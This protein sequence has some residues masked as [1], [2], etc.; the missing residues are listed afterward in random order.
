MGEITTKRKLTLLRSAGVKQLIFESMESF[1]LSVGSLHTREN[2]VEIAHTHCKKL[3]DKYVVQTT[4]K[5]K[6]KQSKQINLE[7]SIEEVKNDPSLTFL[8]G[9]YWTGKNLHDIVIAPTISGVY[10]IRNSILD[11]ISIWEVLLQHVATLFD[12]KVMYDI[13]E[14]IPYLTNLKGNTYKYEDWETKDELKELMEGKSI[15]FTRKY[16]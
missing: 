4:K 1:L 2:I 5:K 8:V 6:I 11:P 13:I 3:E 15:I 10:F 9:M 16:E 14:G 12:I 7:D